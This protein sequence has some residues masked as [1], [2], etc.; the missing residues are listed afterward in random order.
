M[1]ASIVQAAAG[2]GEESLERRVMGDAGIAAVMGTFD[3]EFAAVAR[4]ALRDDDAAMK[5]L[6]SVFATN[7]PTDLIK[8]GYL[9]P[10]S[11]WE[12]KKSPEKAKKRL[13]D[14]GKPY[15][16]DVE[17]ASDV[18]TL[19]ADEDFNR[20]VVAIELNTPLDRDK[21]RQ[22]IEALTQAVNDGHLRN[23]R[24][25]NYRCVL[26][27]PEFSDLMT[28]P[29]MNQ[30]VGLEFTVALR[31][32]RVPEI[33]STSDNFGN[34]KYLGIRRYFAGD[35]ERFME[36][37]GSGRFRNLVT[38]NLGDASGSRGRINHDDAVK[39]LARG[40]FPELRHLILD[41]RGLTSEGLIAVVSEDAS[42]KKLTHLSLVGNHAGDDV[43][44][45]LSEGH[46]PE[47]TN[48]DI[49]FRSGDTYTA[50]RLAGLGNLPRLQRLTLRGV[51]LDKEG[52][53][54]FVRGRFPALH[55]LSVDVSP[56]GKK[57]LKDKFAFLPV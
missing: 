28:C 25:L 37:L 2:G 57:P 39:I 13:L 53:K 10:L 16:I 8:K 21:A 31:S 54:A 22:F 6:D 15:Y 20:N 45:K 56:E 1:G 7:S 32:D 30:L 43:L 41:S 27:D 26:Y 19:I 29:L 33:L 12:Y 23:V 38:L 52:A 55:Y 9:E 50:E 44:Q 14:A 49:E 40:D 46:L 51:S 42:W 11:M 4:R 18:R 47:L 24:A 3:G 48:L 17:S 34:L 5:I 35:K 36:N